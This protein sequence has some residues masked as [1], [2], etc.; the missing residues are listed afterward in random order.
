MSQLTRACHKCGILLEERVEDPTLR[1]SVK[2]VKD[3]LLGEMGHGILTTSPEV[4]LLRESAVKCGQVRLLSRLVSGEN[5]L[6]LA[7]FGETL[8]SIPHRYYITSEQWQRCRPSADGHRILRL[9]D[10]LALLPPTETIVE[11]SPPCPSTPDPVIEEMDVEVVDTPMIWLHKENGP[12][13]PLLCMDYDEAYRKVLFY[14]SLLMDST[15]HRILLSGS[16]DVERKW[17]AYVEKHS[18][19]VE[20]SHILRSAGFHLMAAYIRA[21]APLRDDDLVH[22]W[23]HMEKLLLHGV[24]RAQFHLNLLLH[25]NLFQPLGKMME[26]WQHAQWHH[27]T[28]EEGH[29]WREL[30]DGTFLVNALWLL[31]E[32]LIEFSTVVHARGGLIRL[33]GEAF[34]RTFLPCLYRH[35]LLD[36]VYYL[37]HPPHYHHVDPLSFRASL[38]QVVEDRLALPLTRLSLHKSSLE[39]LFDFSNTHLAY[40]SS[41]VMKR[42]LAYY[43]K[44]EERASTTE[45]KKR[46]TRLLTDYVDIEDLFAKPTH[47]LPPCMARVITAKWYKCFDR[48]NL[49]ALLVDSGYKDVERVTSLMCRDEADNKTNRLTI[50]RIHLEQMKKK[51]AEQEGR[52]IS[53]PCA[54]II[55]STYQDGHLLRCKFEEAKNGTTRRRNHSEQEKEVFR[56][57][58][59]CSMGDPTVRIYSPLDFIS[60][61]L[62]GLNKRV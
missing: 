39:V 52:R 13:S 58:C 62:T 18:P 44:C 37:A 6:I 57:A 15:L 41:P 25:L 31:E 3:S 33:R 19:T 2:G 32:E 42:A 29:F 20:D 43:R 21:N 10:F 47:F 45:G 16:L 23:I 17:L 8:E 5:G 54:T 30:P 35:T 51:Q 28:V 27:Y 1:S 49:V 55:N 7:L 12:D 59:A 48:L 60:H 34:D 4:V 46:E 56:K 26:G 22:Q 36:V 40:H 24:N 9:S 38:L 50:G 61:R 14:C 53:V 11:D